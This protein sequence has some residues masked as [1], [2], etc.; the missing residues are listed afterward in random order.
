VKGE[1]VRIATRSSDLGVRTARL[2][3]ERLALRR[4]DSETFTF[5]TSADKHADDPQSEL[6]GQRPYT[7]ELEV[8]LEKG[9]VDCCVHSLDDLSADPV[10]GLETIALLERADPRDVLVVN[11]V[12]EADS[13]DT[14]P[15]G[16]RVGT[17]SLRRRA[18]LAAMRQDLEIVELRGDVAT[19]LRKVETGKVHAAIFAASELIRLGTPQRITA[20]LEPPVWLPAAGQGAVAIQIRSDDRRMRDLLSSLN[21][22]P[23]ANA[24]EAERAFVAVL[25]GGFHLPIGALAAAGSDDV[26]ILHGFVSDLKGLDV[27]RGQTIVD[28]RSPESSGRALAADLRTRGATSLLMELRSSQ[29]MSAS[30][31]E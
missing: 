17:S 29:F 6:E 13:V 3:S 1:S 7:H 20:Y 2:L 31:P 23:T 9:K 11:P 18:L 26:M 15:A 27:V 10:E 19:R 5:R 21:H 22:I 28:Q 30:Q 14:L 4:I 8:A 25:E 12:T 24:T 16:S